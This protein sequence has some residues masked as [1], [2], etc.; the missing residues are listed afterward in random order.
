MRW[1]IGSSTDIAVDNNQLQ[2]RRNYIRSVTGADVSSWSVMKVNGQIWKEYLCCM[3]N[4]EINGTFITAH[5]GDVHKLCFLSEIRSGEFVVANTCVWGKMSDKKLLNNMRSFKRDIELWFAKQ[6]LSVDINGIL[7]QSTTLN[8][9]GQFGFQT[10][11]SERELFKNRAKGFLEAI[12]VS[13]ERV[14]PIIY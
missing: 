13:F 9:V 6:E 2:A 1:I 3:S 7:R 12:R 10:S 5:I 11:F 4:D 14:S 8:N